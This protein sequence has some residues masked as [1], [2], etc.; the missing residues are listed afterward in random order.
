M[1]WLVAEGGASGA[2]CQ[3]V[4]SGQ[5]AEALLVHLAAEGDPRVS[6]GGSSW[7]QGPWPAWADQLERGSA[8]PAGV[9]GRWATFMG[10]IPRVGPPP[11]PA[12]LSTTPA[13]AEARWRA[14]KYRYPPY[15]YK[16]ENIVVR[17]CGLL[18][19]LNSRERCVKLGFPWLHC[20]SGI[21]KKLGLSKTEAEDIQCSL[22]DNSFSVL[23]VAALIGQALYH[24]LFLARPPP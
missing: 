11:K 4:Q 1:F 16:S 19:T 17:E 5:G 20:Q 15:K 7:L 23:V 8:R 9:K 14:D 3:W 22:C 12:G 2:L 24:E 6:L 13:E 18:S 21:N 10:A